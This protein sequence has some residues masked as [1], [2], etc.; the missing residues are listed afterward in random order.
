MSTFKDII[1]NNTVKYGAILLVGLLLGWLV[2]GGSATHEH[3]GEAA[4]TEE[5]AVVWTCSMHPQIKMDKPGKCP[6]CA[7][8][9]IPL[10]SSG[11]GDEAIDDDAIQMS[12]EAIALANIQTTVVGRQEAIKDIQLYGTIQVDERLQQSQ[13][14]HVNGRIEK[15][16]INFTGESVKQ[17]QLIA[18]IYS[19]DLLN[20]QQELLEA[21]KLTDFQ[22]MLLDA[23]KEKLRLW[24]MSEGQINKVLSTGK[25]SP[26]V[27]I[28]ANTSG[29]VTAKNVNQGDYINQ[30]SVLYSISNMTKLWAIFEAY[31][32]DL[33]FLKEGDLLEYT[34]QSI[35]GK[36][37]QGK[38][39]FINPIIDATS[40]T[41]KIRVETDNKDQA[42]KPEMY[43]TAS[44][45]SPIRAKENQQL[46]IPKSAVL[47][48]GKRSVI[49]VK[50]PHT[51]TPAFKMREI[52]LGP[53]LGDHYIVASGLEDGEE[54]V[55]RGVFTVDSSAQLEGKPSMMNNDTP[56]IAKAEHEAHAMFVVHGNC[57]MCK[58][59]IEKAAKAVPGVVGATWN[60]KDQ[61]LHLNFDSS[62]TDQNKISKAVAQAGHDTALDQAPDQVYKDLPPCC[63]YDRAPMK[64]N[65]TDHTKHGDHQAAATTKG[66]ATQQEHH[67]QGHKQEQ[68]GHAMLTVKG[69][70]AMCKERIET[71][72]KAVAGV[73]TATWDVHGK[74]LHLNFDP[75]KTDQKKVSK[76]IAAAGHDTALDKA[77]DKTYNSLHSCCQYDR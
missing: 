21:Q 47:W 67:K 52:V 11:G 44:I 19:P 68:Q 40:R 27:S 10:K 35:P 32:G 59:R 6:L 63:L 61:L 60:S 72:A 15:L 62:K 28:T 45:K 51:T 65:T 41:A 3:N 13:T 73:S 4:P 48:T 42:L 9:L 24:K 30:G 76:A 69:N 34:L 17:G 55:T 43:A 54:I 49:Y 36:V 26:Y 18:T 64:P 25:V 7:M 12:K 58:A 56:T 46:T 74:V 39:S 2:F 50:Q 37:Y 20:A 77:Q 31:E 57:D 33:P 53:S 71:A 22:P 14:S 38:I 70:C 1:K 66:K 8:D 29:I 16:Y 23:A 75:A 5:A